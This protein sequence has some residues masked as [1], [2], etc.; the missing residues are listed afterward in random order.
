MADEGQD[1]TPSSPPLPKKGSYNLDFD[2]FDDSINPFQPKAKLSSSPPNKSHIPAPL[3]DDEAVDPFKPRAKVASSPPTSP[4]VKARNDIVQPSSEAPG[5]LVDGHLDDCN[6]SKQSD[7][8]VPKQKKVI[9]KPKVQSKL[10]LPKKVKAAQDVMDD[11]QILMPEKAANEEKAEPS[12]SLNQSL[13]D[14]S[15]LQ[16]AGGNSTLDDRKDNIPSSPASSEAVTVLRNHNTETD[17]IKELDNLSQSFSKNGPGNLQDSFNQQERLSDQ[18]SSPQEDKLHHSKNDDM[19]VKTSPEGKQAKKHPAANALANLQAEPI[20]RGADPKSES[21]SEDS[22]FYDAVDYPPVA[23]TKTKLGQKNSTIMDRG[24][25]QQEGG[26]NKETVVQLVQDRPNFALRRVLRYSQSDWNKMKQELELNFQ[27]SLLNKERDWSLLLG[28]RDKKITS[29]EE[30]YQKLKHTNED[31]RMVVAEFEKTISQ[32]QAEKEKVK[33]DCQKS[34][35]TLEGERDQAIEDLQSVE[36]A[37]SDLHRRYEKSKSII[38]GFKRNEEQLKQCV[39]DLQSKLKKAESKLQSLRSQ[40]EE[41]LDKANEDIEKIKKSTKQDVVR[42]EAALKKAELRVS[43]L[44]ES[45]QN[46]EKENLELTAIC[47]ELISKVGS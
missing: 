46:K 44:E 37:F 4:K 23:P 30:T 45:L 22:L 21:S 40:A 1:T 43:S 17:G 19:L 29:L 32:L 25:S 12:R 13:T 35:Q 11:I 8:V 6:N 38:E 39:E 15:L 16:Q 34:V 9:K 18:P 3:L 28:E 41:K 2:S 7:Q 31:M 5:E 14:D 36:S 42:L 26:D 33:S 10:K 20:S 27:A 24:P 47:D